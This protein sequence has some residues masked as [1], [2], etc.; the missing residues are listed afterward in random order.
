MS[1]SQRNWS[2]FVATVSS[3]VS[4]TT[5][6]Q[7]FHI[8]TIRRDTISTVDSFSDR[9]FRVTLG[10]L[11]TEQLS[12]DRRNRASYGLLTLDTVPTFRF[13]VEYVPFK[14]CD[15]CTP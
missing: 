15:V 11:R 2:R 12:D 3:I 6:L 14:T 8:D 13:S 1:M 5:T 7:I 4:S 10:R 9:R